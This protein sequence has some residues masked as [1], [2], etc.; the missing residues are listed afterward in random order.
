MTNKKT[1][2]YL[3]IKK[4]LL[5]LQAILGLTPPGESAVC[6][7]ETQFSYRRGGAKGNPN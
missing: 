2:T 6:F 7:S 5:I 4:L 1:L 3:A